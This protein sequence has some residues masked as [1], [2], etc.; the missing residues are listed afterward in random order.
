MPFYQ[1][2]N[3]CLL[4]GVHKLFIF[5]FRS[6]CVCLESFYSI[7]FIFFASVLH[8]LFSFAS[9]FRLSTFSYLVLCLFLNLQAVSLFCFLVVAL[10][11]TICNF[12]ISL[13]IFKYYYST[14][15]MMYESY[16]NILPVPPPILCATV[17]YFI[18]YLIIHCYKSNAIASNLKNF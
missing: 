8:S 1:S 15:Y 18:I 7:C 11:L 14:S 5:I 16:N 9:F 2:N 6:E 12:N 17:I 13:S 4:F 3:H 10:R